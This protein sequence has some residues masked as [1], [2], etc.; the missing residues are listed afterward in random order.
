MG[1]QIVRQVGSKTG[2]II[3]SA[4]EIPGILEILFQ[5]S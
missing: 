4:I 3:E 5:G 2:K 1:R